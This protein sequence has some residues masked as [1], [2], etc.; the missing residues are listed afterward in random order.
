MLG[1]LGLEGLQEQVVELPVG[2]EGAYPV[3]E[4]ALQ[5]L[6][7][8]DSLAA[9]VPVAAGG[10]HVAPDGCLGASGA[11]HSRSATLAP[12]QLAQQVFV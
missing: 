9:G 2:L 4:L 7:F 6:G 11:V 5:G 12:Q 10:A 3:D 8:D 1:G